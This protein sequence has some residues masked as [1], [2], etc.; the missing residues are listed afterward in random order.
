MAAVIVP[1]PG[2]RA[3]RG[4]PAH[5]ADPARPRPLVAHARSTTPRWPTPAA[6]WP[7]RPPSWSGRDAVT[8]TAVDCRYAGQSHELTV[9]SVAAF[10]EAHQQ[11]NGFARPD[12]PVEVVAIRATA[13]LPS[14]FDLADLP[15]PSRSPAADRPR[16]PSP[17]APSGSPTA[18]PPSP[19]PPAPSCCGGG[20]E[21]RR[22]RAAGA[23]L[24][25][26]RHRRRDGRGAA[27]VGVEPEHQG[28]GRLLGGGVRRV[29]RPARAGRAHPRAPRL[30]ARV[31]A[32]R[33]RRLRRLARA[34]RPRRRQRP[35]RRRHP[36]QRHHRRHP[37]VRRRARLDRLGGEPRPPRRRRR[38]RARLDPRRRHRDPAGGPAHP[39]HPLHRGAARPAARRLP[40]PRRAGRRPR[41]ADRRQR[42]R[43]RAARGARRPA[44]PRGDRLRRAP[45]AGGAGRRC[46][47][48]GGGART[49]STRPARRPTSS[50]RRGSS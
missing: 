42:R 39:A 2:R 1:G 33:H 27:A 12:A 26:R 37:G 41:R 6:G 28:A 19:A 48:V 20:R 5:L 11:R 29:G 13:S 4:R 8:T 34:R 30:D 38:R 32:R 3:L 18:G 31:G 10:H 47:T 15:A 22:R 24:A 9:G 50:A 49:S 25:A 7:P 35:V 43:L 44:V 17:T 40:H 16:S 45:H 46:P 36:P 21:P 14:G 23:D